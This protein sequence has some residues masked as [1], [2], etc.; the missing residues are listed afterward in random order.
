M[1]LSVFRSQQSDRS[2]PLTL[3]LLLLLPQALPLPPSLSLTLTFTLLFVRYE[4]RVIRLFG[5]QAFV[6][7][8]LDRVIVQLT[9]QLIDIVKCALF[10]RGSHLVELDVLISFSFHQ[11]GAHD[12]PVAA[13]SP[14]PRRRHAP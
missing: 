6:L 9:R 7:F 1:R 10:L 12:E 4:E 14:R 2:L 11:D 8:G 13:L 5:P 3:A